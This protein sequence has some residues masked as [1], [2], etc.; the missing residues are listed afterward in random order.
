V[1]FEARVG[2][3]IVRRKS[4]GIFTNIRNCLAFGFEWR[5]FAFAATICAIMVFVGVFA[6]QIR[7]DAPVPVV[8]EHSNSAAEE[9]EFVESPENSKPEN[10]RM[11]ALDLLLVSPG[12]YNNPDQLPRKIHVRYGP[13]S[14]EY[15][16]RN[17]SH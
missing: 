2:N 17:V 1:D 8:A 13:P 15:F 7:Q 4:Q 6:R 12:N 3:E 9:A 10:S 14:E 16:I 11:D 5:R